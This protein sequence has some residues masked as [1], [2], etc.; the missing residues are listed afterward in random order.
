[1]AQ[2]DRPL[3]H[4][5]QPAAL[6]LEHAQLALVNVVVCSSTVAHAV[7]HASQTKVASSSQ[8]QALELHVFPYCC[9]E[10][11]NVHMF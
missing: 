8:V 10:A 1:M 2:L 3:I 4:C 5:L 9:Q 6:N 11:C 7:T